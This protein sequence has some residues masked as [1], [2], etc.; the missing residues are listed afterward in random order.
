MALLASGQVTTTGS[1]QELSAT[2]INPSKFIIK[3]A[4]SNSAQ[5]AIGPAAQPIT[6]VALSSSTGF[7]LDPGDSLEVDRTIQQG[8]VYQL[9]P[10]DV[11]VIGSSGQVVSWLAFG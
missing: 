10:D 1:V 6:G 5:V 8:A 2:E 7:L 3:A 4:A 11:Y 9:T